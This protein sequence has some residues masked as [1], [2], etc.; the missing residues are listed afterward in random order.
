MP[1][2]R[3][4]VKGVADEVQER[5]IGV[6]KACGGEIEAIDSEGT[7]LDQG[8]MEFLGAD[9]FEPGIATGR[10]VHDKHETEI[11]LPTDEANKAD[12]D[13]KRNSAWVA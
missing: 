4:L 1:S 8:A 3:K 2:G 10:G 11:T 6:F 5:G 7:L 13:H 9:E 12:F